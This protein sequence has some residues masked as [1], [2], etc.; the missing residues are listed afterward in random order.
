M[1]PN[2]SKNTKDKSY[3]LWTTFSLK[4]LSNCPSLEKKALFPRSVEIEGSILSCI[5]NNII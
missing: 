1:K 2:L 4:F 3:L 5:N